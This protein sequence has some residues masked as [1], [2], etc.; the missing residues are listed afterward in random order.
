MLFIRDAVAAHGGNLSAYPAQDVERADGPSVAPDPHGQAPAVNSRSQTPASSPGRVQGGTSWIQRM[1]P[2]GAS[3]RS[4]TTK[5]SKAP[6]NTAAAQ[7]PMSSAAFDAHAAHDGLKLDVQRGKTAADLKAE[8]LRSIALHAFP[9]SM[10]DQATSD[11]DVLELC[12]QT[13]REMVVKFMLTRED[14]SGYR[15]STQPR[16]P[17]TAEFSRVDR[18]DWTNALGF[19][20]FEQEIDGQ[21]LNPKD[22]VFKRLLM[23]ARSDGAISFF[24]GPSQIT[25]RSDLGEYVDFAN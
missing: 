5:L 8:E 7:N 20:L 3:L 19:D 25:S 17:Q 14:R 18:A 1:R 10:V 22:P 4:P 24:M 2:Q 9:A 15:M 6:P 21:K 13:V 12:C 23:V 11:R 16:L